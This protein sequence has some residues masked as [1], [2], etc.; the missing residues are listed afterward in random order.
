MP[1]QI[2]PADLDFDTSDLEKA[3]DRVPR[4]ELLLHEEVCGGRKIM[5]SDTGDVWGQRDGEH[6]E[7]AEKSV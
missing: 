4:K 6:V 1:N 2:W 5:L 3:Y 7:R